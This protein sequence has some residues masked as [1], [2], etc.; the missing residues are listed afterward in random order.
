M[1]GVD[2]QSRSVN[3]LIRLDET[4]S[5]LSGVDALHWLPRYTLDI[6]GKFS[7]S[8]STSS[9]PSTTTSWS[10]GYFNFFGRNSTEEQHGRTARFDVLAP[11]QCAGP[12]PD[13][14]GE[15]ML[16]PDPRAG[17]RVGHPIAGAGKI[18]LEK[19][20]RT[21]GGLFFY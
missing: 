8:S 4:V 20:T 18:T 21:C 15:I 10:A 13:F 6:W 7:P 3:P 16:E 11:S 2:A 9:T 1:S 19:E 5:P 14:G 12:D 17:V